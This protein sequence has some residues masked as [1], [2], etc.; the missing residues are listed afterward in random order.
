VSQAKRKHGGH[1]AVINERC[2]K[3]FALW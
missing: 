2:W 1:L 3:S